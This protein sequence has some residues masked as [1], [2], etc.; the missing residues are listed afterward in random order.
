[1]K[2]QEAIDAADRAQHLATRWKELQG[3][4]RALSYDQGPYQARAFAKTGPGL[5]APTC[6][7]DIGEVDR[8]AVVRAVD[9]KERLLRASFAEINVEP[10]TPEDLER[11]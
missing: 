9:E 8:E 4:R 2:Y 6:P 10:P 5:M 11:Y 3:I 1:M 7:I